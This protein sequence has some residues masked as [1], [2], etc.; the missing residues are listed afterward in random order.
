MNPNQVAAFKNL[1]QAQQALKSGDKN[2]ARQFASLAAEQAPEL[3]EVWLLMAALATPRESVA[4]LEKALAI[5]P[6]S[7]RAQKGMLW[8]QG[9][10]KQETEAQQ[11][12]AAVVPPAVIPAAPV[13]SVTQP[14]SVAQPEPVISPEQEPEPA[15]VAPVQETETVP[16]RSRFPILTLLLV[17]VLLA[18]A[19]AAW[20]GFSPVSAF[21]NSTFTVR[22]HGP[23]WATAEIAKSGASLPGATPEATVTAEPTSAPELV[24][25]TPLGFEPS[26]TPLPSV[27]V[28]VPTEIIPLPTDTQVP[29]PTESIAPTSTEIIFAP[30]VTPLPTD[31]IQQAT[32][33]PEPGTIE[34]AS[35]TPLPTDTAAPLPTQYVPPTPKPGDTNSGNSG[36]W[37]DVDLTNQTVYAYEGNTVVNTFIVSTGTWQH[38][39]VTGQ[40]HVYVKFRYKDMSGPGY[41]LPDVPYTMFFYQG[42]AIHGTY[43]HSNF[44]TPMSHGCV[45]LSIPDSEWVY[46]WASV[47][48]LV[49]VHY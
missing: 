35:P 13:G 49:N 31:I 18:L 36:R 6:N 24:S 9:R 39:T 30:T 21:F 7:A 20:Q 28:V 8:A 45:N 2:T 19:W 34:Q 32:A 42:Y 3:E 40:Y 23:A 14:T 5:N 44:G 47:G 15:V 16:A 1:E 38:P 11:A 10:L 37:I 48:T 46:N 41:Y 4:Y 43:W 17:V 29:P 27:T 26:A 25:P 33:T 22:P 12:A